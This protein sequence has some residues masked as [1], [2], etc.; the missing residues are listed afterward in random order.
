MKLFKADTDFSTTI[1]GAITLT[2]CGVNVLVGLFNSILGYPAVTILVPLLI[3]LIY[4]V[5]FCFVRRG[6][7]ERFVRWFT[8]GLFTFFVIPFFWLIDGGSQGG[9]HFFLPA[10]F[11]IIPLLLS[12]SGNL[13]I[14]LVFFVCLASIIAMILIEYRYPELIRVYGQGKTRLLDIGISMGIADFGL[15]VTAMV[16]M[17]A[18]KNERNRVALLS[19]TDELTQAYNRRY[20]NRK[21]LDEM[22]RVRRCDEPP[23]SV[24]LLDIDQFKSV[25]DKYGHD[26]GDEI[27]IL[28][29]RMIH[30]CLRSYD[31]FARWG[32][33]EFLIIS[34][35]TSLDGALVVAERLRARAESTLF[36]GDLRITFSAGVSCFRKDDDLNSIV[37][38]ADEGLYK[39]KSD[40]RNRITAID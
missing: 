3:G 22:S 14:F 11:I 6:M 9:F 35:N 4:F 8:V 5:L 19:V 10:F 13:K 15:F 30:D 37:K 12:K 25:N 33:E 1:T 7:L 32:G 36:P 18:Y 20:M 34:P 39:S 27:L 29:S 16:L 31:Q 2:L 17:N 24:I 23:F 28:F 21:I 38:R 40:G 26:K